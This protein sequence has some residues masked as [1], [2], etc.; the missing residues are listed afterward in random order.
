MVKGVKKSESFA[1]GPLSYPSFTKTYKVDY[2][3]VR[4]DL[5]RARGQV[6]D[7]IY[8]VIATIDVSMPDFIIRDSSVRFLFYPHTGCLKA[9]TK[10]KDLIGADVRGPFRDTLR[11]EFLGPK[12]CDTIFNLVNMSGGALA[13]T[14]MIQQTAL[15]AVKDE[16]YQKFYEKVA[17]C[18][19]DQAERPRS[20]PITAT[21]CVPAPN[22]P[23]LGS[24]T[25]RLETSENEPVRSR[26]FTLDYFELN[27]DLW[28]A[29]SH[30]LDLEH[31][32]FVTL[33]VSTQDL[34][35]RDADISFLRQP[36]K[37]CSLMKSRIK[38][39]VGACLA[40]DF[41]QRIGKDFAGAEGCG[42]ANCLLNGVPHG[43]MQFYLMRNSIVAKIKPAQEALCREGL[44]QDC[45]ACSS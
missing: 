3:R 29:C 45:I 30:V 15:A 39:I 34:I 40:T 6:E 7:P 33:D 28:R 18:I 36:R 20:R 16:D 1:G 42:V 8:N 22:E 23:K 41:R 26:R 9:A 44:K 31:N 37:G 4:E 19:V 25:A 27:D 13:Y 35:V 24:D 5:W 38:K 12:G 17:G 10:I 21:E 43:F 2:Y 32:F 14:Y 11:R